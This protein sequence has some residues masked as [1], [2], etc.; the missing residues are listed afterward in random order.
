MGRNVKRDKIDESK[1]KR[2]YH[3][4]KLTRELTR[5]KLS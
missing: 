5:E 4:A 2:S 1:D 3:K